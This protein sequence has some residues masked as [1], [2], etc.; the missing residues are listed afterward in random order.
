MLRR[1]SE[2][3]RG[4][5]WPRAAQKPFLSAIRKLLILKGRDLADI[6]AHKQMSVRFIISCA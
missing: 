1:V 5:H 2:V 4:S 3:R 6:V